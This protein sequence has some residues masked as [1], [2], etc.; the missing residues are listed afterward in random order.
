[1]R[2]GDIFHIG[3]NVLSTAVD[4]VTGTILAQLGSVTDGDYAYSDGAEWYQHVGFASLPSDPIGGKSAAEC[5]AIKGTRD[6]IIASRDIRG[7]AIYGNIKPGETCLY[8]GGTDGKSQ[9]RVLI[10][11]NGSVT[12]YT[13]DKNTVEG[14]AVYLRVAP[15]GLSFIAPWGTMTFDS[16][17]FHL[18][19]NAGPRIDLG[20]IVLPSSIPLPE[21]LL[22]E[23]GTYATIS[24][25]SV[26]LAG[27][28]VMLG[29]GSVYGSALNSISATLTKPPP[30]P[31]TPMIDLI[32]PSAV[33][34]ISQ[35]VV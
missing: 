17:G 23:L 7:Q 27:S 12:I 20:G 1:M 6:A 28:T 19:T 9:G 10:K 5:I 2:I 15:D 18:R 35:G 13:T 14:Q 22:S 21:K 32:L 31:L 4:A 26:K 24:A 8:A 30:A 16:T 33:V 29:V 11:D 34:Y 3:M 25:G